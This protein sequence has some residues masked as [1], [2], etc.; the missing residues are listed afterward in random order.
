MKRRRSLALLLTVVGA[1]IA[2]IGL[3]LI[4]LPL[5]LTVSGVLIAAFGLLAVEVTP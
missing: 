2:C 4:S 5:A 3:A 1:T